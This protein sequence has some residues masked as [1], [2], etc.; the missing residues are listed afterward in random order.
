VSG[1]VEP[2]RDRLKTSNF[3]LL[4]IPIEIQ[5]LERGQK[6]VCTDSDRLPEELAL[7]EQDIERLTQAE[8]VYI[9]HRNH[10]PK[11]ALTTQRFN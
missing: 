2:L 1:R 7:T 6:L 3:V 5:N 9:T 4:K 11:N 8:L 10:S